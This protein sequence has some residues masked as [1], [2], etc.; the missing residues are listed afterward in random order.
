MK[1][2][3]DFMTIIMNLD[4]LINVY[5]YVSH[6]FDE[7]VEFDLY[8]KIVIQFSNESE[9]DKFIN[10]NPDTDCYVLCHDWIDNKY[11]YILYTLEEAAFEDVCEI[12]EK[13]ECD[14]YQ[15]LLEDNHISSHEISEK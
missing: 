8:S 6:Q 14:I 1:K 11:Q 4:D 13:Y 5:T 2:Y 7:D 10:D 3:V 15:F 9:Y 12:F